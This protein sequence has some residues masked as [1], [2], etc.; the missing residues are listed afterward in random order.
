MD[1]CSLGG[2]T[3]RARYEASSASMADLAMVFSLLTGH[4]VV[5]KTG[6]TGVVP[7]HLTFVPDKSML[8][9]PGPPGYAGN[10]RPRLTRAR[11]SLLPYRSS[12][13]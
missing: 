11:P 2:V 9:T 3:G 4:T 10:P 7:V 12:W 5:D 13:G 1:Y 6:I 8:P